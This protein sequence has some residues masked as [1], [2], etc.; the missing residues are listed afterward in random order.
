MAVSSCVTCH[1]QVTEP[2]ELVILRTL[3]ERATANAVQPVDANYTVELQKLLDSYIRASKLEEAMAVKK[4]LEKPGGSADESAKEPPHL[5]IL[6]KQWER[7][8]QKSVQPVNAT[9][10]KELQKL[11]ESLTRAAKLEEAAVVKKEFE[12]MSAGTVARRPDPFVGIKWVTQSGTQF[13]FEADGTG[14]QSYENR[15]TPLKWTKGPNDVLTVEGEAQFRTATWYF[16][17]TDEKTGVFGESPDKLDKALT[18]K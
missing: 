12:K 3:W 11:L 8:R 9:Y 6:R 14:L 4:A 17:F 5:V 10:A 15:K 2:A 18:A 7:A 16:K 13:T 1:A